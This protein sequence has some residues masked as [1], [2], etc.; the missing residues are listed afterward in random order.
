MSFSQ[1]F[2]ETRTRKSTFLCQINAIVDWQPINSIYKKGFNA[3][4]RPSCSGLL[5]FKML[6]LEIWY[7]LSDPEVEELVNENPFSYDVL[8]YCP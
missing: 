1:I 8:W 5:V 6:L 4:D 7:K 2:V 3:D